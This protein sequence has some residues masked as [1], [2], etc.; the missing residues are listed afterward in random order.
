MPCSHKSKPTNGAVCQRPGRNIQAVKHTPFEIRSWTSI[1]GE[2]TSGR[3]AVS[4]AEKLSPDVV[5]M[6]LAMPLL[7]GVEATRQ[8]LRA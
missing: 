6:D 7:N 2:A 8:L 1:V 4:M 5:I 3:E